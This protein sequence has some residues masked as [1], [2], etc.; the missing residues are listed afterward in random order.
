MRGS[1]S[2]YYW[3]AANARVRLRRASEIPDQV[4]SIPSTSCRYLASGN[5]AL[6]DL[7]DLH[8]ASKSHLQVV[9]SERVCHLLRFGEFCVDS[10]HRTYDA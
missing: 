2:W 10:G 1:S 6:D 8:A 3:P 7:H 4:K 9:V 5:Y